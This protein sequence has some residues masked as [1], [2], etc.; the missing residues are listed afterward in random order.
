M[1][2]LLDSF[3]PSGLNYEPCTSTCQPSCSETALPC[4]FNCEEMCGC[5]NEYVVDEATC[6]SREE[7]GCVLP[8]GGYLQVFYE[9]KGTSKSEK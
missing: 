9:L 3:C 6:V 5:S 2:L 1:S 7:C 8:D 4:L